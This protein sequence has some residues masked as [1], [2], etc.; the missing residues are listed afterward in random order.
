MKHS[1]ITFESEKQKRGDV[2]FKVRTKNFKVND[3][4]KELAKTYPCVYKIDGGCLVYYKTECLIPEFNNKKIPLLLVLGNPASE[5]V[6]EGM[7]YSYMGDKE[8]P[9]NHKFWGLLRNSGLLEF[10]CESLYEPLKKWDIKRRNEIRKK[11][12]LD[13]EYESKCKIYIYPYYSFPTSKKEEGV[14]KLKRYIDDKYA[15]MELFEKERFE[16]FLREYKEIKKII[17]FQENA[18]REVKNII[19]GH[20]TFKRIRLYPLLKIRN[21]RVRNSSETLL[22]ILQKESISISIQK[23]GK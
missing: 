14:A 3:K 6:N 10:R 9:K 8:S 23:N 13:G 1:Q 11:A 20:E 22:E 4:I 16:T 17:V 7:L 2:I 19:C 18:H 5:S 15:D 12:L 21:F